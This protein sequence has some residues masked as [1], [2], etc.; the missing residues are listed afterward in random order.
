M[1]DQALSYE[2]GRSHFVFDDKSA[3]I[4]HPK[5]DC[6]TYFSKDGKKIR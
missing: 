2:D 1:I 4:L 6:F 5:G 3:I